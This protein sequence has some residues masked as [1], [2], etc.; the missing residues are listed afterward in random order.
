MA[1]SRSSTPRSLSPDIPV[2]SYPTP[3]SGDLMVIQDVDTRLPGYLPQEYGASHP[4]TRN[5]PDLKLVYQFPLDNENNFMW[6]RRVYA[7]D[8]VSQDDYNYAIKYSA[9]AFDHPIYIRTYVLPRDG[10]VPQPTGSSDPVY[11]S[12]ILVNEEVTRLKDDQD[13]GQLDSLFLKVVR[14]YETI[15]GPPLTKKVKGSASVIP[16]KFQAARSVTVTKTIVTPDT[17]PEDVDPSVIESSVEQTSFAKAEKST[18]T[19]DSTSVILTG[20]K[21]TPQGQ[22]AQVTEQLVDTGSSDETYTATA[23]T[24]DASADVLGNGKSLKTVST[25]D[26]VFSEQTYTA[27][28]P[29]VLPEKFRVA[30]PTT[31]S[32][33][34]DAGTAATP[35]LSGGQLSASQE[36]VTLFKVKKSLTTR[37]SLS[38]ATLTGSKETPQQQLGKVI[39]TYD[40]TG[41]QT[42]TLSA[43]VVDAS[44]EALGDGGTIMSV[45]SVDSVFSEQ[46]YSSEIPDVLPQKFR[47]LVPSVTSSDVEA[48][49]AAEPILGTGDLSATEEQITIFKKKKRKTHR[50]LTSS[51]TLVNQK[52]T[53]QGQIA[54]VTEVLASGDQSVTPSALVIEGGVEALGDG[55]T[56]ATTATV[57]SVFSEQTYSSEIPD[58]LPQKFRALVPSVTS[59]DVEAGTA[60]EPI[61]G[62]GDLSAT[63]EQITIFK[64]KKRKTHR[65]LTSSKTLVNQKI[66]PQGQIATVTEVLASGDQS[67]TPSALVIEGGVEAL[68]DGSTVATTA[69][70]DSVFSEQT[71]SSEKPLWGIPM[72]FKVANPPLKQSSVTAGQVSESDVTLGTYDMDAQAEQ[73]TEYKKKVTKSAMSSDDVTLAG[74][75]T[76]TWGVETVTEVLKST[77]GTASGAKGTKESSI[78]PLGDGRA[79]EKTILYGGGTLYEVRSDE[80]TGIVI[81][82]EKSIVDPRSDLPSI[83][84]YQRVDRQPIDVWNSIQIVS[85]V[86]LNSLPKPETWAAVSH[87]SF[88]DVLIEAG[89]TFRTDTGGGGGASGVN[90]N[91]IPPTRSWDIDSESNS[92]VQYRAEPYLKKKKG[93]SGPVNV[94]VTRTYYP[95]LPTAQQAVTVI[96]Q[97]YGTMVVSGYG[98]SSAGK[99]RAFGTG[100]ETYGTA[101]S[102]S[103]SLSSS[104]SVS[105]VGPFVWDTSTLTTTGGLAVNPTS[106]TDYLQTTKGDPLSTYLSSLSSNASASA[107]LFLPTSSKVLKS[108]DTIVID[109]HVEKWRFGIWVQEVVVATYP[110][111]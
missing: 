92:T 97:V 46:T 94:Q 49:T 3:N 73:M 33:E 60:A 83:D 36:Q 108:G 62:T 89:V 78:D 5:Y 32:S 35:T 22:I 15:P 55:S 16:P 96:E 4:D 21:L 66:T 17:D 71:Y 25:V 41:Q 79:V 26:S 43:T 109:S 37:D 85:S 53:P 80:T 45:T 98:S 57:D 76:G 13:D 81:S 10:Y 59:S 42:P 103:S 102:S 39:E 2:V 100:T 40:P 31:T 12:A 99:V 50:D 27:Q 95:Y 18:A 101:A 65:D 56:V 91:T 75:Q 88:P 6:I 61:L 34:I 74:S 70:V 111:Y 28:R 86:D 105:E 9:D 90:F 82:M 38:G 52:I 67:V 11:P 8:R 68:G 51:K 93:H 23:L 64:K 63:E 84:I 44:V 104:V 24:I 107:A 48:G 54:T 20:T 87:Y 14:T 7:A 1:T 72:K 69:T 106:S 47:A 30:L 110:S 77:V 58:V 29:D 19:I